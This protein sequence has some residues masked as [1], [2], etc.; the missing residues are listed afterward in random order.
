MLMLEQGLEARVTILVAASQ[1]LQRLG[2]RAEGEGDALLDLAGIRVA[3]TVVDGE[4]VAA[5]SDVGPLC[6]SRCCVQWHAARHGSCVNRQNRDNK[7]AQKRSWVPET[8]Q[9]SVLGKQHRRQ[10]R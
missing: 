5:S 1:R 2:L 7:P 8:C 9:A 10:R 6:A 4:L 3:S